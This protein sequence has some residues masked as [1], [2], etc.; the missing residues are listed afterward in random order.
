MFVDDPDVRAHRFRLNLRR[1]RRPMRGRAVTMLCDLLALALAQL[2]HGEENR[3][4]KS[5]FAGACVGFLMRKP[6]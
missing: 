4:R 5:A 1:R 2:S 3:G 6:V